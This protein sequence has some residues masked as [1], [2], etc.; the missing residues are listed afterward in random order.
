MEFLHLYKQII[1]FLEAE[2]LE[3]Q[4][5]VPLLLSVKLLDKR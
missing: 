1:D 3:A 5:I 2:G 4:D